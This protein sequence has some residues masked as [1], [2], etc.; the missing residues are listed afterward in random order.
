MLDFT[1]IEEPIVIP[2]KLRNNSFRF[3]KV[4]KGQKKPL[5][6]G[7]TTTANYSY[8]D[9][10]LLDHISNG[11]NYGVLCGCGGL[12]VVDFD[13]LDRCK[14]LGVNA[15]LPETFTV[16]TPGTGGEHLYYL[17]PD[18]EKTFDLYDP[19]IR[20][21]KGF[22][23]KLGDVQAKGTFVVGPNCKREKGSYQII[24]DAEIATISW[25]ELKK[26]LNCCRF[27][28]EDKP[29]RDPD[30]KEFEPDPRIVEFK[31]KISISEVI[32]EF[33]D[34]KDEGNGQFVGVCPFHDD[35]DPSFRIYEET[36]AEPAHYH[37]Y[38]CQEHGDVIEF[39]KKHENL[40]FPQ[41]VAWLA[42]WA[43]IPTPL[44]Q[45]PLMQAP[46]MEPLPSLEEALEVTKDLAQRVKEDLKA[47]FEPETLKALAKIEEE[48]PGDFES[49][50]NGLRGKVSLK[51]LDK[52]IKAQKPKAKVLDS[53]YFVVDGEICKWKGDGEAP[54]P[55][56]L[57]N[58]EAK[59]VEDVTYDDGAEKIRKLTIEGKQKSGQN[60]P[61]IEVL[62]K[63]FSSMS[64]VSEKW[65]ATAIVRAGNGN[66]DYLREAIQI[67]SGEIKEKNVYGHS[68][69]RKIGDEWVYLHR[70]G[71]IAAD[72]LVEGVD[73]NLGDDGSNL[74][75]FCLPMPPKGK[76]LKMD[77]EGSLTLMKLA[78]D[79][80]MIP[81]LAAI[82]RSILGEAVPMKLTLFI[83]GPTGC[84]KSQLAGLAQSHFGPAF[85]GSHLPA[86]FSSTANA[87]ER[88]A[89]LTKD[90]I[91]T[92]DDYAPGLSET[93]ARKVT[94]IAE[95]LIRN[96]GNRAGRG[97]MNADSSLKK[98]YCSRAGL[99]MTGED[100]PPMESIRGRM[101]ILELSHED[102]NL[103]ILTAAQKA[104]EE[105]IF[106]GAISGFIQWLAP[107]MDDLKE[108]LKDEEIQLRDG[109]LEKEFGSAHGR[110]PEN[111][112]SLMLGWKTYLSFAVAVGAI[113]EVRKQELIARAEAAFEEI[114]SSQREFTKSEDPT[115][116]FFE[117]IKTAL[118]SGKAH[119]D[120]K[121][122]MRVNYEHPEPPENT[123]LWGWSK[124][125]TTDDEWVAAG[126][127]IG[128]VDGC[129][130]YLEPGAAYSVANI[131][132]RE[133]NTFLP[134]EKTLWKRINEKGLL[135]STEKGKNSVKAKV[136]GTWQRVL[137]VSADLIL[138]E[139]N[140]PKGVVQTVLGEKG[141]TC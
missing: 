92:I 120:A 116:K 68:G 111:L 113:T 49:I 11:G 61:K 112:A 10:K 60:L 45:A 93:H 25:E 140:A 80:V 95:R 33:V 38:G 99:I 79:R 51:K 29:P 13:N 89:F 75:D 72:G 129:C 42:D 90:A 124:R 32:G 134:G 5:E 47:A 48:S 132:A 12:V 14:E 2:E 69:W 59:I 104:A 115:V 91:F 106:A 118:M 40:K 54:V 103:E 125:L 62:S 3:L 37:C 7:Y 57:C 76:E 114:A 107:Q 17:V 82:Y 55:S 73:V 77:I 6:E 110:T 141:A 22:F 135:L 121:D 23:K 100:C 26:S 34:L 50:K 119:V 53:S 139:Q 36:D 8:N 24:D 97:R 46:P 101:V 122:A 27:T 86:N 128:W 70:E 16:R 108:T 43:K 137:H 87:I 94:A 18:L 84:R 66:K 88:Q 126:P 64:W 127:R 44:M 98:E 133:H 85:N 19:E 15:H 58:F 138:G 63:R 31:K 130:L 52:A 117:M 30:K 1:Q 20:D 28:K 71:A 123:N 67:L 109:Y 4:Q 65:P 39:I 102:V 81:L 41:A 35:H 9:P 131:V 136:G 74:N 83:I 78:H 96:Q 56:P 105:G 21:E